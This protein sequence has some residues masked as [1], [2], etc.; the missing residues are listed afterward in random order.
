MTSTNH[1]DEQTIELFILKSRDLESRSG[2][3]ELHLRDCAGCREIHES[4]ASFYAD[5]DNGLHASDENLPATTDEYLPLKPKHYVGEY[6]DQSSIRQVDIALPFRVARWVAR[7]PYAS[8]TG[9]AAMV[10][11]SVLLF[12]SSPS[13]KDAII[14]DWNPAVG[15]LTGEMLLVQNKYGQDLDEIYVGSY[16]GGL[17]G[18]ERQLVSCFDVDGDGINEVI[19]VVRMGDNPDG[20]GSVTCKSIRDN[21]ILWSIHLR[22]N[23]IFPGDDENVHDRYDCPAIQVGD[24]DKDGKPEVYILAHHRDLYP[25]YLEKIDALTGEEI[26]LYVHSG[27][28]NSLQVVDL[29]GDG[30]KELLL[31]GINNGYAAGCLAVLDPR[32]LNGYGP[33]QGKYIPQGYQKGSEEAYIL[34]PKSIVGQTSMKQDRWSIANGLEIDSSSQTFTVSIND[35][36]ESNELSA[37][38]YL[39]FGY[40]LKVQKHYTASNYDIAAKRLFEE[41]KIPRLPDASYFQDEYFKT[42]RYWDGEGWVNQPIQNRQYQEA[43]P[44]SK[45]PF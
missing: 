19:W 2:E 6:R 10:S 3:I 32:S 36:L 26:A 8:T 15:K 18:F 22:R 33:T 41:K 30:I 23:L 9:F 16:T 20:V 43:L 28:L 5:V 42:L 35:N 37:T 14:T 40:D 1:L 17:G 25:S 38:F 21:R 27:H 7:H 34:I 24:L 31:T 44:K 12:L 4:I 45:N 39:V 29:D 11:L 13:K